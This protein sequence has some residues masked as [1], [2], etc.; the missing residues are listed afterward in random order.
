MYIYIYVYK[1]IDICAHIYICIYILKM[2][3]FFSIIYSRDGK[4]MKER[5]VEIAM[6]G[7]QL[8]IYIYITCI[9]ALL[10]DRKRVKDLM[11]MLGFDKTVDQ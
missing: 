3:I 7:V 10:K 5:S 4:I 6:Y 2:H 11:L 9:T 1:Y 8:N